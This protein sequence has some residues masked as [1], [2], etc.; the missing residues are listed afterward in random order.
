MDGFSTDKSL[1]LLFGDAPDEFMP[2]DA[3]FPQYVDELN[4]RSKRVHEPGGGPLAGKAP[5]LA[6]GQTAGGLPMMQPAAGAAGGMQ[7]PFM[8][9]QPLGAQQ[10]GML[11]P[12]MAGAAAGQLNGGM[13]LPLP[14][15]MGLPR[16]MLGMQVPGLMPGGGP[17]LMGLNLPLDYGAA[18]G[19]GLTAAGPNLSGTLSGGHGDDDGSGDGKHKKTEA[20]K[21][22]QQRYRERKK[23]KFNEME[24]TIEALSKQLQQLQALQSRNQILE[25]LNGDLHAQLLHREREVERL[26]L[27]LDA[28][29]ER[30]LGSGP[31]S[32]S[33]DGATPASL[34]PL[35]CNDEG[36]VSC[37]V[38]P[39]D[40]A[41]IDF[42][43]GFSDQMERLRH[44]LTQHDLLECGATPPAGSVSKELTAELA[45]I[46]GRS[47]QLCQ[48]AL[49]AEGVKVMELI[50]KDPTS[51]STV[52]TAAEQQRWQA[53]LDTMHL[54]G[55]QQ[56]ALLL[57]R[58]SHLQRMRSIYQERHNL[59]MQ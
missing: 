13:Q 45:Q 48:A 8:G 16:G 1:E 23:A 3:F 37:D 35:E 40:L 46:V 11:L 33:A 21:V 7:P 27:A 30:S 12:G 6:Q 55:Q 4:S 42:K 57:N 50:S 28:S 47:C 43:Q 17:Q 5:K 10:Q 24:S 19:G 54:T 31:S 44:F 26:K 52:G 18:S 49:R 58:R 22:A 56:E 53:C 9:M 36:C 14:V 38:L 34:P 39:Q 59:N 2:V 29:A 32:P 51:L 25:G 15:P 41:G 20:N